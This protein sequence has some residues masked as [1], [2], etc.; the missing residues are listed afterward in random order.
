MKARSLPIPS[1]RTPSEA[2][3][4]SASPEF[5]KVAVHIGK[6]CCNATGVQLIGGSK[7]CVHD[8]SA[9]I[10]W[11]STLYVHS[12]VVTIKV[13]RRNAVQFKQLT[14]ESVIYNKK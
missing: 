11:V 5:F 10:H 7:A 2:I 8:S 4:A 13:L 12:Q 1:M 9:C 14:A 6:N 3:A